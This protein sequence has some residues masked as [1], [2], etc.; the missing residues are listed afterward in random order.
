MRASN[1]MV[2]LYVHEMSRAVRFYRD[3]LGMDVVSES[4]GWSLL[5]CGD[6]FVGLHLIE[7][8]TSEGLTPHA[9]LNLQVENLETAIDHVRKAGGSLRTVREAD[10]P[11]VPVRLAE[12]RDS[13]G[14]EFELRQYMSRNAG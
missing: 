4:A 9:G 1:L 10:P 5:A 8:D 13:E 6:A 7:P 11:R 3:A 2:I 14:N 12:V